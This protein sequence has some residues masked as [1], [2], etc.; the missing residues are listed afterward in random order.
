MKRRTFIT[1]GA[2][3]AAAVAGGDLL[4]RPLEAEAASKLALPAGT[5]VFN[6][7]RPGDFLNRPT[8]LA[9]MGK[10]VRNLFLMSP[11]RGEAGS[12]QNRNSYAFRATWKQMGP[13]DVFL[14][15]NVGTFAQAKAQA[16]RHLNA[17]ARIPYRFR[18]H[19][20]Q[21]T[22]QPGKG[23]GRGGNGGIHSFVK[24]HPNFNNFQAM[25]FH[26]VGHSVDHA[27]TPRQ[28]ELWKQATLADQ[29]AA[30]RFNGALS[31]YARQHP[32]REGFASA[33]VPWYSYR[34]YRGRLT[35]QQRQ[36]IRE[37]MPN[38]RRFLN[39]HFPVN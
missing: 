15:A 25:M 36:F 20:D 2:T 34:K 39:N 7:I 4:L 11:I 32:W 31:S 14:T 10:K 5:A 23:T 1:L 16:E 33:V 26:E 9:F 30:P 27:L 17:L 12:Y 19:I 22:I 8:K 18:K 21:I 38:R 35:P 13:V 37:Q 3:G 28:K 29:K 6:T 24:Q